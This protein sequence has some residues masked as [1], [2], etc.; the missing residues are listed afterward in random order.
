MQGLG[1]KSYGGT[2]VAYPPHYQAPTNGAVL[3]PSLRRKL[4]PEPRRCE[5][6]TNEHGSDYCAMVYIWW[7]GRGDGMW[8]PCVAI[9]AQIMRLGLSADAH[10]RQTGVITPRKR[11]VGGLMWEYSR[12]VMHIG[13]GD[14]RA[15]GQLVAQEAYASQ[16]EQGK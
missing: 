9:Q 14:K 5:A 8:Q 13:G 11:G 4:S 7:G 16:K 15:H 10:C 2:I 1:E 12:T 6:I 3:K